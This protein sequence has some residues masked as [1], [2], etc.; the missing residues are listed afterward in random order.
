MIN[1]KTLANQWSQ[2]VAKI[3]ALGPMRP[4]SICSQKVKYQ[5]KEGLKENGPYPILTYK[6]SGKTRTVRLRSSDEIK[7]AEKQIENFRDF[8]SL[9]KELVSIGKDLADYEMA[10]QTEEKKNCSKASVPSKKKKRRQSL[11]S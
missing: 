10:A 7:I 5:A 4:G 2:V 9:T 6:E 1:L 11:S 3:A 8:Q